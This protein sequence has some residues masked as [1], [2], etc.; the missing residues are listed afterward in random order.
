VVEEAGMRM[1]PARLLVTALVYIM[2]AAA[3]EAMRLHA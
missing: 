1:I 2:L 3:I